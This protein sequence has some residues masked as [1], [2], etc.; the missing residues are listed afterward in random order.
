MFGQLETKPTDWFYEKM[1]ELNSCGNT[2][3]R[4]DDM[5]R[6]GRKGGTK[7]H[8]ECLWTTGTRIKCTTRERIIN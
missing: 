1:T 5:N 6:E 2:E 4:E 8:G 7:W 3:K